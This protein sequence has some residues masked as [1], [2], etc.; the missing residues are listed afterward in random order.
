MIST[1]IQFYLIFGIDFFPDVLLEFENCLVVLEN[2]NV[3]FMTVFFLI[4]HL[5]FGSNS[6]LPLFEVVPS[7]L[8]SSLTFL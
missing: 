3:N 1:R 7:F 5:F 8:N 2:Q 4:F 6:K